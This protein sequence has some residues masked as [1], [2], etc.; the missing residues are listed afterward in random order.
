LKNSLLKFLSILAACGIANSSYSLTI[1]P[2][3]DGSITND[4]N[5]AAM[6]AAINAAIQVEQSHLADN[7]TVNIHFTNDVNISLGESR[8]VGNDYDYTNFLSKLTNSATSQNDTNGYARI[9]N[10]STNDPLVGTNKIYI[11]KAPA[12]LL[13]LT[14]TTGQDGFDSTIHLNMSLMNFTRPPSDPDK[15]DLAQVTEHEMDEVLGISSDLPDLTEISPIDLFR[16][17]TN[18]A[19][20]YVTNDD[21]A[22]FSVDGTNLLA[23][24]NMDSGGDY[25]DWWSVNYPT[26]WSPVTGDTLYY[27]QVQDAFSGPGNA[28]DIGPAE[29]ASL[30]VVGW[31]L[32][33]PVP[34][35]TIVRSGANQFTLSWT[36]TATG[37][38]LQENT[39]LLTSA[40]WVTSAT[41]AT[42]PAV[43]ALTTAKK[44][45]RLY[46]AA[47]P[48]VAQS[49]IVTLDLSISPDQLKT[50]RITQQ[51]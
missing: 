40:T 18:L 4:P 21:N 26:N 45:Y 49:K 2:T 12:R 41:G 29:L 37:F 38:V 1:V 24:Y 48:S 28:L 9:P 23:R 15:Y 3:F 34:V 32:A 27:P 25:G 22:Y 16:Y 8:T 11:N 14:T 47:T 7:V 43:I 5:G 30:D 50:H 19:R 13:G 36:N 10:T 51:P 35:L 33:T 46:K 31:T 20:T 44:F 39:N 17:T 6:V 42:N